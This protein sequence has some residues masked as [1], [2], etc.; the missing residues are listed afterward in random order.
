MPNAATGTTR[1]DKR[2]L[3]LDQ[4]LMEYLGRFVRSRLLHVI[5]DEHANWG[6]LFV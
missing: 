2:C 1:H 6:C 3:G 5:D 4:A